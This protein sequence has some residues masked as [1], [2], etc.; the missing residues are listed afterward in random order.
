[1]FERTGAWLGSTL[2]VAILVVGVATGALTPVTMLIAAWFEN[3]SVAIVT[4][5]ALRR[6]PRRGP[7]LAGIGVTAG[8][9]PDRQLRP[10][11]RE[12]IVPAGCAAGAFAWHFGGFV[13]GHGMAIAVIVFS[14]ALLRSGPFDAGL[15]DDLPS[16]WAIGLMALATILRAWRRPPTRRP[17]L[18]AYAG[19]LPVHLATYLLLALSLEATATSGG[20]SA[21]IGWLV[22]GLLVVGDV[23]RVAVAGR[24]DSLAD[25]RPSA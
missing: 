10:G 16:L 25:G 5:R 24:G 12:G 22:V 15:G 8:Q 6:G 17:V 1:M 21:T 14:T 18:A 2:G 20:P 11:D 23:L 3:V 13:L 7:T 4:F 19:L 9:A